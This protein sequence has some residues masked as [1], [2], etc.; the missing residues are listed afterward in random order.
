M[1]RDGFYKSILNLC[2]HTRHPDTPVLKGERERVD[3]VI[4]KQGILCRTCRLIESCRSADYKDAEP[5]LNKGVSIRARSLRS[6][7][8]LRCTP[9]RRVP[10]APSSVVTHTTRTLV[11]FWIKCCKLNVCGLLS[12]F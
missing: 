7:T 11:H 4:S 9:P 2:R 3:D 1:N 8:R 6:K 10:L 12:T 5:S